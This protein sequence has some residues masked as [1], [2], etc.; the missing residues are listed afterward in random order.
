MGNVW[1]AESEMC[2]ADEC[3]AGLMRA[4]IAQRWAGDVGD[5]Q[6]PTHGSSRKS[7]SVGGVVGSGWGMLN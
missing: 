1:I 7:W 5:D 2:T 6:D 4:K 3:A